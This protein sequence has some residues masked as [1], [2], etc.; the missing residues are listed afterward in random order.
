MSR[1]AAVRRAGTRR[2]DLGAA[3]RRRSA[4]SAARLPAGLAAPG[5]ALDEDR[6]SRRRATAPRCPGRRSRRTGPARA[7]LDVAED[8]EQR[9]ADAI[10]GGP[11]RASRRRAQAPPAQRPATT[12]MRRTGSSASARARR[13]ARRRAARA[14]APRAPGRR[15]AAPR[16]AA[17]ALEQLRVLGQPRDAELRQPGWRVPM[18]SPSP[19]SSRSISASS[20]PSVCSASSALQPRATRCGPEQQ[21]QRR[22]LAAADRARAAG[23][24][25]RCRSARRPRRAS[26][27]RW[28]RRCRPR[29]P[30]SRRGRRPRRPRTAPSPPASRA[31]ASGRAAARPEVGE[32]AGRA[33]AR[34]RPVAARAWS[35]SNS[36]DQRADHERLAPGAQLLADALVG[37]RPLGSPLDRRAWRSAGARAAA[38]AARSRRGR[39]RR[40]A[41]ACAGSAWP[42]CAGRAGA[43]PAGPLAHP[44]PPAG[45]PR[46]G[47]ARRRPPRPARRTRP[48]SSISA[49]VPTTSASSPEA[50]LPSISAPAR[51]GRRAG[52]QRDADQLAGQQRLHRARSAARRASRSAPS[53]PPGIPCSTARSIANSAT[54]VLPEPTSPISSRCIGRARARSLVDRRPSPRA[55]RPW[56]RTAAARRASGASV[57]GLVERR[58]PQRCPRRRRAGAAGRAGRAAARRTPAAG[59]P[60]LGD[61]RSAPRQRRRAG[62]PGARPRAA[63]AGS[64][65]TTSAIAPRC[66]RTSARICGRGDAPRSPGSG[67]RR[68]RSSAASSGRR[69]GADAEA[70]AR[71]VL[72]VQRRAAS[73]AGSG[74]SHG[75]LKNVAFITP[76]P[77]AD[78]GLDQRPHAAAAH[79]PR[80]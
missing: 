25:A 60:A 38:R 44:A 10:G 4:P 24:A 37:A 11:R 5:S 65:S 27:S 35:S 75:W 8:R 57:A 33:A 46:S 69:V 7:A 36:A 15:R 68:R 78:D 18:S 48:S 34:T 74:A 55:G 45:A 31:G 49:C 70:V 23:A 59:A 66:S 63:P 64:G 39:R 79:R 62:R 6:P 13:R 16:R 22:V 9:L 26:R 77:S 61:R 51:R 47:A 12:L 40:S 76:L 53:A 67:R 42:S 52:Q 19:R 58:A 32:L 56:A 72:A 3:H 17:G 28:G 71:L 30:W 73:R 29:S 54:T 14:R 21:A 1:A 80:P 50:E 41:R 2:R 20:N 43:R